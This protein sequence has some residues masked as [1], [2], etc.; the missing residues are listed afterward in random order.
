MAPLGEFNGKRPGKGNP[1]KERFQPTLG[2]FEESPQEEELDKKE[3]QRVAEEAKKPK[4]PKRTNGGLGFSYVQRQPQFTPNLPIIQE[5]DEDQHEPD[6]TPKR[7]G[8]RKGK[9]R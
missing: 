5:V 2:G 1:K 8:N 7:K 9:S 6:Q 3:Q 4:I